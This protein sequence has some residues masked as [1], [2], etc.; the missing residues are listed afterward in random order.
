M[1][2]TDKPVVLYFTPSLHC[3]KCGRATNV[4]YYDDWS[5]GLQVLCFQHGFVN[6][7]PRD[8]KPVPYHLAEMHHSIER[9]VIGHYNGF[10]TATVIGECPLANVP[11][12]EAITQHDRDYFTSE[13]DYHQQADGIEP[14]AFQVRYEEVYEG[15]EDTA[16]RKEI[17]AVWSYIWQTFT[18]H[19]DVSTESEQ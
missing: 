18:L 8:T 6:F 12:H 17:Y 15:E 7:T 16:I 19:A 10:G 11:G 3:E 1:E 14:R 9:F 4:G 13:E 2:S 5:I